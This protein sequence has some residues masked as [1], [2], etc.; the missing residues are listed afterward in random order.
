MTKTVLTLALSILS[1]SAY[2]QDNDAL[3]AACKA[4]AQRLCANVQP[5]GGRIL[6]CMRTQQAQLSDACKSALSARKP[7]SSS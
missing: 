5:G 1:V 7:R 6:K 3:R 4:D 2:A